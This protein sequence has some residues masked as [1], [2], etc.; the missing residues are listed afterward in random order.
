[1][2]R[3]RISQLFVSF[4]N[5]LHVSHV[6]FAELGHSRGPL[7]TRKTAVPPFD[8]VRGYMLIRSC[9]LPLMTAHVVD[10]PDAHELYTRLSPEIENVSPM[11]DFVFSSEYPVDSPPKQR[12]QIFVKFTQQPVRPLGRRGFITN[13]M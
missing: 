12:T 10:V 4:T 5:F 3:V 1:M 11:V 6:G 7:G 13:E 2:F 8:Q 9:L